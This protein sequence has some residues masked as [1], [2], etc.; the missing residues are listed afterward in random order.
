[1]PNV[2]GLDPATKLI[3]SLT[4]GGSRP[5][6]P[7]TIVSLDGSIITLTNA[8]GENILSVDMAPAKPRIK[9]ALA[10]IDG[11]TITAVNAVL[12]PFGKVKQYWRTEEYRWHPNNGPASPVLGKALRLPG[13]Q[14][15]CPRSRPRS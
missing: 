4:Q 7:H 11:D 1:M 12:R 10:K 15:L 3:L 13:R 5:Y 9:P 6:G 2:V 8:N 14:A